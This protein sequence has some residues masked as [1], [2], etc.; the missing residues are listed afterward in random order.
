MG[1]SDFSPSSSSSEAA[2]GDQGL[3]A[4]QSA[5]ER[6]R[7]PLSERQNHFTEILKRFLD[8]GARPMGDSPRSVPFA[9]AGAHGAGWRGLLAPP[10][11][12]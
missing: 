2:K 6:I 3:V 1:L 12:G 10:G 8:L 11:V 9:N 4:G 5:E 7:F